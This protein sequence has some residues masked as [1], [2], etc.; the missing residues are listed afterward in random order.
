MEPLHIYTDSA[1]DMT[2]DELEAM[3]VELI[4]L[5][6]T[7]EKKS[8][9][10]DKKKENSFLWKLLEQNERIT[11]S[12]PSPE[13]FIKVFNS[14]KEKDEE[15]IYIG[16]SS[17][18]SGTFQCANLALQL[19]DYDKI[20]LFDTQSGTIGEKLFVY[21]A[22]ELRKQGASI[23]KIIEELNK[24]VPKVK[25]Y[26]VMDTLEYLAKSGRIPKSIASIGNV[27]KVKPIVTVKDGTIELAK[28]I[29]SKRKGLLELQNI[30]K[31]SAIDQSQKI[32]PIY[33]ADV[34]N[35]LELIQSIGKNMASPQELGIIIGTHIG[36][37]IYGFAYVEK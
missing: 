24:M 10:D 19:M 37:N 28:M 32:I 6:L 23:E 2:L 11:T 22:V 14:A 5:T 8:I 16:V 13:E 7:V 29:R 15:G 34:S 27:A 31:A 21:K 3:N 26:A 33:S 36:P 4:P 9:L 1:S 35:C 18:I 25:M 20:A 30:I 12:Q 17:K